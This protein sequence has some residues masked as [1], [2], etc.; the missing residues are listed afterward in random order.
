MDVEVLIVLKVL[1]KILHRELLIVG[2]VDIVNLL[3]LKECLLITEDL[4]EEV[5][6]DLRF[7]REIILYY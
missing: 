6:V 3:L 2:D 1:P 5:F 7:G 4:F